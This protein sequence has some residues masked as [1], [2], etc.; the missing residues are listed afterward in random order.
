M[1]EIFH[2]LDIAASGAHLSTVWLD[3]LADNIA[4]Q[5]TIHPAD[6]E[7]FRAKLIYAREKGSSGL[8]PFPVRKPGI[9]SGDG[10]AAVG[11]LKS[12]GQSQAVYDPTHPLADEEGRVWRPVV[13]IAAQM[14]DLIIA[15]RSYSLN[16]QVIQQGRE[17]Y[18]AAMRI[19]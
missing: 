10:V 5:D 12:T 16:I 9:E 1:S 11:L 4:N 8:F 14:T 3:V 2:T 17:A 15:G 7:P 18:E 6:E 19:G 13:D